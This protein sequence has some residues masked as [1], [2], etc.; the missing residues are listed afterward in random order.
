MPTEM[1]PGSPATRRIASSASSG[2]FVANPVLENQYY[3][4]SS[5]DRVA[6]REFIRAPY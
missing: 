1:N 6:G 5:F 3:A 4:D 2:T